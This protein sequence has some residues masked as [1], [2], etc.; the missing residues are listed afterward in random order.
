MLE[1]GSVLLP[2][3]ILQCRFLPFS[4]TRLSWICML[5]RRKEC[6]MGRKFWM[7]HSSLRDRLPQA[8]FCLFVA[9][10]A[11]IQLHLRDILRH[12]F[13]FWVVS[14]ISTSRTSV[15]QG[16]FLKSDPKLW[17]SLEAHSLEILTNE[18]LRWNPET[19]GHKRYF[20]Q[21]GNKMRYLARNE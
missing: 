3:S 6:W 17:N 1:D 14:R 19:L 18:F 2:P 12:R 13:C 7:P 15:L 20:I 8:P 5:S 16:G 21:N 11:Q 10:S 4:H 9:V